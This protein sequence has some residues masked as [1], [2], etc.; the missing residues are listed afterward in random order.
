MQLISM[1]NGFVRGDDDDDDDEKERE[2]ERKRKTLL[3]GP[4]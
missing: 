1:W 3:I 2:Q 4:K